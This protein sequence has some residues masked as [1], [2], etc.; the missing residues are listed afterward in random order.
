M[1]TA[2]TIDLTGKTVGEIELPAVFDADYRPDL[3]KKAVLAAQA[4]RLQPYGPSLYAG[5]K[6]SATG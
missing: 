4:N 2:K 1:A 3:I 5:M 6:T